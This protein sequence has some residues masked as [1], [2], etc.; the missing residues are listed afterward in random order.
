MSRNSLP[1]TDGC[2]K[3]LLA[4]FCSCLCKPRNLWIMM[5]MRILIIITSVCLLN[6][7]SLGDNQCHSSLTSNSCS[8]LEQSLP[9]FLSWLCSVPSSRFP[10][11]AAP[12]G[13][14]RPSH[15][16]R[17]QVF[18]APTLVYSQ[19]IEALGFKSAKWPFSA[20]TWHRPSLV[21]RGSCL[22]WGAG[23]KIPPDPW[24]EHSEILEML[25]AV[26]PA[27]GDWGGQFSN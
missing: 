17:S 2:I 21:A 15:W 9:W 27:Q 1:D 19:H 25:T 14:V 10:L 22:T 13:A 18:P 8:L 26:T 7:Y 11:S 3:L 20:G 16:V 5:V 6:I 4:Q 23:V 12:S 24:H